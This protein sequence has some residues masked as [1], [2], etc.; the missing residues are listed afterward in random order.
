MNRLERQG[1]MKFRFLSYER[2]SAL[3]SLATERQE[4][5]KFRFLSYE[6]DPASRFLAAAPNRLVRGRRQRA[7][8]AFPAFGKQLWRSVD[9]IDSGRPL[10]PSLAEQMNVKPWVI[11]AL[12]TAEA[13][14]VDDENKLESV[15]IWLSWFPPEQ[16]PARHEWQAFA[17][18]A[19]ATG[20]LALL[21]EISVSELLR[22]SSFRWRP[23]AQSV[24]GTSPSDVVRAVLSHFTRR[25]FVPEIY[26]QAAHEGVDLPT[27]F[28]K[29][30]FDDLPAATRRHFGKALFGEKGTAA[31]V[32]T[33]RNWSFSNG[34]P[35]SMPGGTIARN[36][37]SELPT[38]DPLIDVAQ[39]VGDCQV[40]PLTC[41]DDMIEEGLALCHCLGRYALRAAFD[42]CLPISIRT[43]NGERMSSALLRLDNN[44]AVQIFDHRGY[45][46]QAPSAR[47]TNLVKDLVQAL[48][49]NR[50][51]KERWKDGCRARR[52]EFGRDVPETWNS[53]QFYFKPARDWVFSA[54]Y[55]PLLAAAASGLSRDRWMADQ[56]IVDHA[57]WY[58][59]RFGARYPESE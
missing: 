5:M 12:R 24:E 58:A 42:C 32:E 27:G 47:A 36:H 9:A 40:V 3:R 7:L 6:G 13:D 57:K 1:Q 8:L 49:E 20:D 59:A 31:L 46:N 43:A 44:D 21:L 16:L 2:D 48:T 39:F 23:I 50:A 22:R 29:L 38:W 53:Y 25:V 10:L 56:R 30:K 15:A 51:L 19:K 45:R 34:D 18:A 4:Q 33:C 35:L 52:R 37:L 17:R 14:F 26:L 54:F 11:R 55:A 28:F 41:A